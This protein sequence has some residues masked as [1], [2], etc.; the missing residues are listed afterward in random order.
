MVVFCVFTGCLFVVIRLMVASCV[1]TGCLF[2][3]IRLI[4][5]MCVITCLAC[6]EFVVFLFQLFSDLIMVFN[7]N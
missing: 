2:V 6:I 1:F 4:V 5:V 3:V 7:R